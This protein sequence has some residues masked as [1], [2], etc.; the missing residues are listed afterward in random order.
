MRFGP[1]HSI[2]NLMLKAGVLGLMRQFMA[3][4]GFL[5]IETPDI[6]ASLHRKVPRDYLV[7]E[8]CASGK[9]LCT[10]TVSTS[11][12]SG[13]LDGIPAMTRISRSPRASV[14]RILRAHRKPEFTQADMELLAC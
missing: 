6:C 10:A 13:L 11:C 4:E 2:R 3:N 9:F 7:P 5:E 14:T 12:S 8:P 1:E